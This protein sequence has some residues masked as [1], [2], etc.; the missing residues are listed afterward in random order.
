MIRSRTVFFTNISHEFRTPLTLIITPLKTLIESHHSDTFKKSLEPIL[1]NSNRLLRL[2]NQ[3]LDFSKLE[4]GK[5]ELNFETIE[6]KSFFSII[7]DSFDSYAKTQKIKLN[8]ENL[9]EPIH[10]LIDRDKIE[11]IVYNLISNAIKYEDKPGKVN[12]KVRIEIL[13]NKKLDLEFIIQNHSKTIPKSELGLIF[14]RFY[15]SETRSNYEQGTGIG[16][17]LAKELANMHNGDLIVRSDKEFGTIFTL[18]LM[19]DI[20]NHQEIDSQETKLTTITELDRIENIDEVDDDPSEK[21]LVLIIEDNPELRNYI[22]D[23]VKSKYKTIIAKDGGEG[24]NKAF[25]HIPDIIIS[26]IMMP[27]LTGTELTKQLKSDNRTSHIPIILLTAK[28]SQE[29]KIEG[30]ESGADCYLT[31]PFEPKELILYLDNLI[32]ARK[33][34]QKQI[35]TKKTNQ[36]SVFSTNKLDKDFIEKI[37]FNY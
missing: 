31:K 14:K 12:V 2:I 29:N 26:D 23:Y 36:I 1:L 10:V 15:Q 13:E 16:L 34:I 27:N 20:V 22:R 3:L 17:S 24:L 18:S 21:I 33:K 25:K 5:M 37:R 9:S 30:L 6:I 4:A 7:A 11:K 32:F 35:Q 28:A 8:L 19:L